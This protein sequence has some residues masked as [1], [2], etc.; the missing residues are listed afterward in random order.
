MVIKSS[1]LGIELHFNLTA[2]YSNFYLKSFYFIAD[3]YKGIDT[4][5]KIQTF[6]LRLYI[7]ANEKTN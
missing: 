3:F 1:P 4:A 7:F 5:V 2:I 6:F